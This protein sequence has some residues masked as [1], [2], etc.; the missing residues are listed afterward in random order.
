MVRPEVEQ[1][2]MLGSFPA[3][4][5]ADVVTIKRQEELLQRII[6]PITDEEAVQLVK[7]FGP[8]DYFGGAW[9]LLHLV[10][11]APHWPIEDCLAKTSG[12]W[13]SRLRDRA[14]RAGKG[15]I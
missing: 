7:L 4:C 14:S 12:E 10:E 2:V 13:I 11:T 15:P 9:T 8:D 3:S 1:L 6:P 5:I